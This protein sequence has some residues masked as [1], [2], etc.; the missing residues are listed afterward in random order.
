MTFLRLLL[1]GGFI[2]ITA[3]AFSADENTEDIIDTL[4]TH[5][6]YVIPT[7]YNVKLIPYFKEDEER[8]DIYLTFKTNIEKHQTNGRIIIYGEINATIHIFHP[9]IKISLNSSNSIH[10]LS[11][12]LIERDDINLKLKEH[13]PHLAEKIEYD[14][15]TQ[16]CVLHFEYEIL[17]KKYVLNI[18][19]L[20][21]INTSEDDNI[22]LKTTYIKKSENEKSWD[23]THFPTIEAQRLFPCWDKPAIKATFNVSIKHHCNYSVFSNMPIERRENAQE[24]MHKYLLNNTE[25][26]MQWTYFGTTPSMP[27]HLVMVMITSICFFRETSIIY[28]ENLHSIAHKI[29]AA[30]SITRGIVYQWFGNLINPSWWS[31]LWLNDGLI[32]LLGMDVM[33]AVNAIEH[34]KNSEILDLLIVQTQYESLQLD[35]CNFTQSLLSEASNPPFIQDALYE[36][37][38]NTKDKLFLKYLVNGWTKYVNYPTLKIERNYSAKK[39]HIAIENYDFLE[40]NLLWIPVTFTTQSHLDFTNVASPLDDE[41]LIL[42]SSTLGNQIDIVE[43]GWV[44]FNLQQ[45]GYYR[46]NYD[47]KNWQRIAKYLNSREYI[48]IHVLNRAKIIDDA[49]RFMITQQLDSF[50]FWNLTSYLAQETN[51]IAWYPMIKAFEYMSSVFPFIDTDSRVNII[52]VN[53]LKISFIKKCGKYYRFN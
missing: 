47:S 36:T 20:N 52:K 16:N 38:P 27:A 10:Y 45:V 25:V 14:N 2:F 31:K 49:F 42:I 18:K 11:A 53:S 40:N 17:P 8:D 35:D 1:Y 48:K 30:W 50:I 21:T 29:E 51:Y 39:M 22:F 34:Y 3:I 37:Y 12:E 13:Y 5:N 4:V 33:N 19:F 15:V 46:V 26:C 9:I 44:I 23:K 24:K 43:D 28:N 6:N 7:H 41:R 32:T